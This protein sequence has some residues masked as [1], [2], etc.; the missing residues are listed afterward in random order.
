M[1]GVP[2]YELSYY[3]T[4]VRQR[5]QQAQELNIRLDEAVLGVQTGKYKS[6]YEA[7]KDLT[8]LHSERRTIASGALKITTYILL[9]Y[10]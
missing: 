7:A 10:E 3:L 6:S 5:S 1:G 4:M 9:S 8:Y 2:S